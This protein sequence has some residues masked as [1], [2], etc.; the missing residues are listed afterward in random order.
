LYLAGRAAEIAG[1]G[2]SL[3]PRDVAEALPLAFAE[4]EGDAVGSDLHSEVVLDLA[5]AY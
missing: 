4:L 5:P 3:L 2:R 1:R